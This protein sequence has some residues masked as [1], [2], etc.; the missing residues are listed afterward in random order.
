MLFV[1]AKLIEKGGAAHL[2]AAPPLLNILYIGKTDRVF[3]VITALFY[4]LCKRQCIMI[5]CHMVFERCI[6]Y[7]G[8]E[9][10]I[11]KFE[12]D[13]WIA[14]FLNFAGLFCLVSKRNAFG[15]FRGDRYFF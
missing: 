4:I 1:I 11:M 9:I 13:R 14:E 5:I 8:A 2:N 15:L 3:A 12:V 7:Y 10:D 6:V